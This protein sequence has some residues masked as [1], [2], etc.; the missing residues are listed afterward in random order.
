[1]L[2]G[3][4]STVTAAVAIHPNGR[5]YVTVSTPGVNDPV[6]IPVEDPIDAVVL[7]TLHVPPVAASLRFVVRPRHTFRLPVI[8]ASG[9]TVAT[10]DTLQFSDEVN[11][12]VAS[13]EFTPITTPDVRF[14]VATLVFR[15]LHVPLVASL[16]VVVVPTHT[17]TLPAIALGSGFTVTIVDVTQLVLSV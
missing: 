13:P 4:G 12:I 7:L 3:F 1:M 11:T 5:V 16:S 14:T 2:D 6:T 10:T 17:S 8:G 9:F 15:L